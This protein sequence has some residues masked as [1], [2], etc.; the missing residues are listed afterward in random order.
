[1]AGNT[2]KTPTAATDALAAP[3]EAPETSLDWRKH[4][5]YSDEPPF[6][7]P[8]VLRAMK[9]GGSERMLV[10]NEE[11]QR[12]IERLQSRLTQSAKQ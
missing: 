1:M 8:C 11:W 7:N 2:C 9:A 6:N 5:L 10:A 4:P 12:E 3:V